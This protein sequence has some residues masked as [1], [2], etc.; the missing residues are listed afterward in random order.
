MLI[1]KQKVDI[2]R[3]LMETA[4]H[5]TKSFPIQMY[6]DCFASYEQCVIRWHWHSE[7]EIILASKGCV[8]VFVQEDS[9]I[10]Q[11]G[12]AVFVNANMLHMARPVDHQSNIMIAFVFQPRLIFGAENSVFHL[13]YTLPIV[14]NPKI[15]YFLFANLS[16]STLPFLESLYALKDLNTIGDEFHI[17]NILSTIWLDL[18]Q[19]ATPF[20]RYKRSNVPT[21]QNRME[22]MILFIEQHF[23]NPITIDDIAR[24]ASVSRS[25]CCRCFTQ[26][27]KMSPIQYV[28]HY[29]IDR[30]TKLL[31]HTNDPVLDIALSCGFCSSSHLGKHFKQRMN[32]SPLAYRKLHHRDEE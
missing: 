30:A 32:T 22:K 2:D 28:N 25:E 31:L 4:I 9:F 5:G 13:K 11:Q 8:E 23:Q 12:E 26:W 27:V 24:V 20:L 16:T 6:E 17:R 3:S 10:L 21:Q 15:P 29:R 19:N 1:D 7:C 18:Y 14:E